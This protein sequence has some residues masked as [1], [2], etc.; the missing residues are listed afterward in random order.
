MVN[1][2]P[3]PLYPQKWPG[4]YCIRG[5][6]GPRGRSG[7]VR[8][9]LPPLGFNRWTIQPVASHYTDYAVPALSSS[10][11]ILDVCVL[12]Y[13]LM[14]VGGNNDDTIFLWAT[15]QIIW[16]NGNLLLVHLRHRCI[17]RHKWLFGNI[18][19]VCNKTA[20]CGN[21][22][23][24]DQFLCTTLYKNNRGGIKIYSLQVGSG[25]SEGIFWRGEGG[26]W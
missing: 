16:E 17:K 9:I 13:M 19:S 11:N 12:I 26:L 15:S 5:W 25:V 7:Q 3:W 4:T 14:N 10:V 18:W 21:H 20:V 6:V 2:M 24:R 23:N 22:S 1:A 8:Q